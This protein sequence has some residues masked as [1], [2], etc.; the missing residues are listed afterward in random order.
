ME[1]NTVHVSSQIVYMLS[2]KTLPT[3]LCW[4]ILFG[5]ASGEIQ[6][7][8]V[9]DWNLLYEILRTVIPLTI[10]NHKNLQIVLYPIFYYCRGE[11]SR[12][13]KTNRK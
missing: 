11:I 4:N 6:V 10:E 5:G 9:S 7:L 8:V 3:L 1:M 13:L 12:W 2:R